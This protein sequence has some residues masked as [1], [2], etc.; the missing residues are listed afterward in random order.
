MALKKL[1]QTKWTAYGAKI[2]PTGPM[3]QR[4]YYVFNVFSPA[5]TREKLAYM[6]N[7]P[8]KRGLVKEPGEWPW[9]SWRFYFLEDASLLAMERV[10]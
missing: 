1:F 3:W 10:P 7:N 6:H 8:V 5:K 2:D 4:K 9:S